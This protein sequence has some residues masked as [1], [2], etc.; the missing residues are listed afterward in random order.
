MNWFCNFCFNFN[1]CFFQISSINSITNSSLR[2]LHFIMRDTLQKLIEKDYENVFTQPVS[3]EAVP[4]Y[5]GIISNPMDFRTMGEK[6][7]QGLYKTMTDFKVI[8]INGVL[9][10]IRF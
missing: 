3:E 8:N 6:L 2:P 10:K 5:H 4:G 1:I 9:S 7:D